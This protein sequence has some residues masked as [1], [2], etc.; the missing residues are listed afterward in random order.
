M[1]EQTNAPGAGG[2]QGGDGSRGEWHEY[3]STPPQ[4]EQVR[5]LLRVLVRDLARRADRLGDGPAT[6]ALV[7]IAAAL[8]ELAERG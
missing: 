4:S 8:A 5:D 7:E 1:I 3:G 6:A 2:A